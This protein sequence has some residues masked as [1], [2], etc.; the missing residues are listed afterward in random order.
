MAARDPKEVAQIVLEFD[1]LIEELEDYHD[2]YDAHV[3]TIR[4]ERVD[5]LRRIEDKHGRPPT[6]D[7][8]GPAWHGSEPS[9]CKRQGAGRN[10]QEADSR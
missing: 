3:E 9:S 2:Q 6:E 4:K 1:G 10:H 7:E 5:R 8:G